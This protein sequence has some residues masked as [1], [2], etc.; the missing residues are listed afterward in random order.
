MDRRKFIR[1]AVAGS[2]TGIIAPKTVLASASNMAGGLYYTKDAP[3][4]WSKKAAGHLPKIEVSG[5]K[6]QIVTPHEMKAHGHYIIKHIVLDKNFKYI[7][8]NMFDPTKTKSPIS[9]FTIADY[10]GPLHVLSVCNI[11]DTWLNVT[12]IS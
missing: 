10:H 4:R 7:T 1:L 11:H 5:N 9:N 12:E 3:G 6:L 8:E 2:A